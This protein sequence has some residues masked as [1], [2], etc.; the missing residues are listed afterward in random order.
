MIGRPHP[1]ARDTGVCADT[2][3][4]SQ[5]ISL[6]VPALNEAENLVE[7]IPQA[8]AVLEGMKVDYEVLVIDDGST[9]GTPKVMRQ[10]CAGVST[11]AE[12]PVAPQRRQGRRPHHRLRSCRERHLRDD[13]CRRSG[14]AGRRSPRWWPSSTKDSIW[15]PAAVRLGRTDS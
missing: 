3:A 9:D 12:R 4:R 14:R 6:V 15:S 8:I 13:G 10:L 11:P 5:S 2:S 1:L 7:T